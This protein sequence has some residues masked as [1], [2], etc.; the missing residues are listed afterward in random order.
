MGWEPPP[1][2]LLGGNDT[3]L[4]H[5]PSAFPSCYALTQLLSVPPP[6]GL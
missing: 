1:S 3:F 2:S 5:F 6:A 4:L